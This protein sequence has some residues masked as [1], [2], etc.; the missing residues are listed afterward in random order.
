MASEVATAIGFLFRVIRRGFASGTTRVP[1]GCSQPD[2]SATTICW[3]E[4]DPRRLKRA[5]N[6][7]ERRAMRRGPLSLELPDADDA[8]FGRLREILLVPFE[9]AASGA[10]LCGGD[11]SAALIEYVG[12]RQHRRLTVALT[13]SVG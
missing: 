3:N 1:L 8:D 2:T 11:H 10:T 12:N 5:L 6:R 9:E 7:R 4:H 13:N